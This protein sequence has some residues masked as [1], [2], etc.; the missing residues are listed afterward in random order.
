[1]R[2]QINYDDGNDNPRHYLPL[3]TVM[4]VIFITN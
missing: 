2:D 1:M 4:N 3:D